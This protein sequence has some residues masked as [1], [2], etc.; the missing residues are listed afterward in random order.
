M[1]MYDIAEMMII[2]TQCYH[3]HSGAYVAEVDSER[4]T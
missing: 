3:S 2:S 1:I 4:L